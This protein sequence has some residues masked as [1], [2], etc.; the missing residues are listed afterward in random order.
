MKLV[1]VNSSSYIDFN[2][3]WHVR[4]NNSPSYKKF[5]NFRS[6]SGTDMKFYDLS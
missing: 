2:P 1:D 4:K 3:I 5:H 6:V